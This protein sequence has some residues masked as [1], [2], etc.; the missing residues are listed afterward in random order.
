MAR[1][2][3]LVAAA[4]FAAVATVAAPATALADL[5]VVVTIKPIHSLVTRLTEGMGTPRLLVDGTASPH[6]F[7]LKPSHAR[8]INNADVFIRVSEAVEPFTGKIVKALPETVRV[9]TLENAPGMTLLDVRNSASFEQHAAADEGAGARAADGHHGAIDGHIWLNPDNAKAIVAYLTEILAER[10]PADAAKLR[11]NAAQLIADID[12]LTAELE[13]STGSIKD[14]PFLVFH[15]A[16]QYFGKRFGVNAVG[17][18]TV[19]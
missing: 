19:S 2:K 18:V 9:V 15:D 13:E 10:S 1:V 7:S 4:V 14:R 5:D 8:A 11:L 16:Y 6:A 12:A 3:S 17:S